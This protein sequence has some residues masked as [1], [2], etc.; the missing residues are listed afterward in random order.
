MKLKKL[1]VALSSLL[2]LCSCGKTYEVPPIMG[3]GG[4]NGTQAP[5]ES[6][7]GDNEQGNTEDNPIKNTDPIDIYLVLSS[8]GLY[9]G[10]KGKT[11]D[12]KMLENAIVFNAK[13]GTELP[14]KEQIT[15]IPG[16]KGEFEGW[17]SYEGGG[18]PKIYDKV[19]ADPGKILY[20]LFKNGNGSSNPVVPVDPSNPNKMTT[21]YLDATEKLNSEDDQTWATGGA[22][23]TMYVYS[24]LED[25]NEYIKMTNGGNG[26]YSANVCLDLYTNVLFLRHANG[27]QVTKDDGYWNKTGNLLFVP[28]MNCFKV[29]SW[30]SGGYWTTR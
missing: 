29:T 7:T 6:E 14:T 4:T 16:S 19:P 9:N 10:E 15:A 22:E 11:I 18:F 23:V 24:P 13:P 1:I 25:K 21:I 12:D 2:L 30:N 8:V 5:E 28:N 27:A 17:V 26:I 20:A 3:N